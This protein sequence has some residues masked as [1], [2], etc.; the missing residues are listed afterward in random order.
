MTQIRTT[1]I[2]DKRPSGWRYVRTEEV[3]V[4][5]PADD[6]IEATLEFVKQH[7]A[8]AQKIVQAEADRTLEVESEFCRKVGLNA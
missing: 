5:D 4:P 3:P 2:W 6:G 1:T 8:A 7:E